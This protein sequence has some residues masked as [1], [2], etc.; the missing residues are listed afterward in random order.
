MTT[1]L[2]H[3]RADRHSTA[4]DHASHLSPSADG[5]VPESG[6]HQAH[7]VQPTAPSA[8]LPGPPEHDHHGRE[9][10]SRG[11]GTATA[12]SRIMAVRATAAAT[13]TTEILPA[14][15]IHTSAIR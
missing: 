12:A 13:A 6:E 11:G 5:R 7:Q 10:P 9:Q 8:H 1:S 2:E 3:L 14:E 4:D 15:Q